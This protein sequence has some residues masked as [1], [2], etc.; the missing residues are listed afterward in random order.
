MKIA[1]TILPLMVICCG[2]AHQLSQSMQQPQ[3][4]QLSFQQL[5]QQQPPQQQLLQEQLLASI[6]D[7]A[8]QETAS[9]GR[10]QITTV[11]IYGKRKASGVPFPVPFV[12]VS[13]Y[14]LQAWL[15]D[16]KEDGGAAG[17]AVGGATSTKIISK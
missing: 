17:G 4:Q 7:R 16:L 2:G 11:V 8:L 10:D 3:Q 13:H 14:V 6:R 1:Q 9:Y 5:T 12:F 15:E